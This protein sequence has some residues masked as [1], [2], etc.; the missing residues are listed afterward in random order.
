MAI[1][2]PVFTGVSEKTHKNAKRERY[3]IIAAAIIFFDVKILRFFK[4]SSSTISKN[5]INRIWSCFII[6][7]YNQ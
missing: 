6:Y 2:Q 7:K 3:E 4:I 5:M 1:N